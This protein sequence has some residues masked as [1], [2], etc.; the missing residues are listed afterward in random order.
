MSLAGKS[1]DYVLDADHI[2]QAV[3]L[4]RVT[5]DEDLERQLSHNKV[6]LIELKQVFEMLTGDEKYEESSTQI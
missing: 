3:P 6:V 5:T 4:Q 1:R 2:V